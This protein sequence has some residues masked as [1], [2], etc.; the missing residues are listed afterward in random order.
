M[1]KI[2]PFTLGFIL[3]AMI[4]GTG[5]YLESQFSIF[6][7]FPDQIP[8]N[9]EDWK[10]GNANI[11][12]G[13][14]RDVLRMLE[15]ERPDKETTEDLLGPSGYIES[16]QLNGAKYYLVYHIDRGHRFFVVPYLLKLGIAFHNDDTYSHNIIW[17]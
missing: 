6:R 9:S 13:M 4:F 7:S 15:S 16:A 17:D 11:R 5:W 2:I 10:S 3:G 12:G 8:F 14:Y 1:K